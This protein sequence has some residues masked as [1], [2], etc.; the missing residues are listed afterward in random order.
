MHE[1]IMTYQSNTHPEM[2]QNIQTG[3]ES[4]SD[5]HPQS[6]QTDQTLGSHCEAICFHPPRPVCFS[7]ELPPGSEVKVI[8]EDNVE[9]LQFILYI[10][11]LLRNMMSA[12]KA[13]L[14]MIFLFPRWDMLAPWRVYMSI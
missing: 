4:K 8:K 2:N 7:K 12:T 13:L 3:T 10:Y 11:A 1:S 5:C 9:S 6:L 14:K